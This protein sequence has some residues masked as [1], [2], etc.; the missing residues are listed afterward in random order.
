MIKSKKPK[1]VFAPHVE[2]SAGIMLPDEYIKTVAREV[3]DVGGLFVLDCIASGCFWL[4]MEEL[5]VDVLITAP[6]KG[7]SGPACAGLI[8]MSARGHAACMASTNSTSFCMDMKKWVGLMETYENNGHM[9]HCTMP[10]D[11]L[12]AFR[13]AAAEHFEYGLQRLKRQQ[14]LVGRAV[15][16]LLE[17]QGYKSVAANG[18]GAP[19]VVVAYPDDDGYKSG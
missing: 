8:M 10:T 11:A 5:G 3:H 12:T 7:W 18:F 2:T 17:N 15:R 13:D 14:V 6:Q 4:D 9:Y 19:G 16:S 1:V